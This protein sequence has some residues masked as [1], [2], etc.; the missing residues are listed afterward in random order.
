MASFDIM[1]ATSFGY[2]TAWRERNYLVYLAAVPVLIKFI[3][4]MTVAMLGWQD[5][6]M[7]QG[8]IMLPSYFADGWMLSHFIRLIFLEQRWPFR[9]TGDEAQDRAALQDRAR[10]ILGGT[11]AFVVVEYLMAGFVDAFYQLSLVLAESQTP[12]SNGVSMLMAL[13]A[14]S[15]I[16]LFRYFWFYIPVA[17]QYPLPYFSMALRGFRTS[18]YMLGTWLGCVVPGVMLYNMLGMLLIPRPA[19]G[20]HGMGAEFIA[21]I[22]NVTLDTMTLLIVTAAMAYAIRA[23]IADW[24]KQQRTY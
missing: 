18:L 4:H 14:A 23:M 3:C 1:A 10:S 21:G 6:F 7:R 15:L 24:Q 13:G 8:M 16:W 5:Q 20:E 11:L 2:R 9:R 17:V 22:L 19:S 12:P